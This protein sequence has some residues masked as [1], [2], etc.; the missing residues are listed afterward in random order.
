MKKGLIIIISLF[1]TAQAFCQLNPIQNL[2]WDHWYEYPENCFSLSWDEPDS[3]T[4]DT[5]V[6]YNIY[7]D[8]VLYSFTTDRSFG[9]N[10][11]IGAPATAF[12]DFIYPAPF[13]ICVKAVYNSDS[14]EAECGE[15]ANC[16]G[17]MIST[18]EIEKE[19]IIVF[20]NPT[21]GIL[22]IVNHNIISVEVF[23][24]SGQ[25]IIKTLPTGNIEN[26][27]LRNNPKG[28]YLIKVVSKDNSFTR[29]I[30]YN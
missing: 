20:P 24:L 23:N 27:D 4:L 2:V 29:K 26:I 21:N 14:I 16:L 25:T 10:P 5:L 11:C 22:R 8:G 12:C 9:C 13:T 30:I 18:D 15:T 6:G 17:I 28:V 1:I 3:N 19:E 7:Q